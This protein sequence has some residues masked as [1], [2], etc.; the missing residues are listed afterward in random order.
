[1]HVNDEESREL[2]S[3]RLQ[4]FAGTLSSQ[5]QDNASKK[6]NIEERW[7]EDTRQKHGRYDAETE[8]KLEEAGGSKAFSNATRRK[9]KVAKSRLSD[10]VLPADDRNYS[11]SPTPIPDLV[12]AREGDVMQGPNG[13]QIDK[14]KFAAAVEEEAREAAES[15]AKVIDDQLTEARYG[16]KCRDVIDFAVDL[17][18]GILKG[19]VI[20]G[21]TRK[22]WEADPESGLSVL[23]IVQDLAPGVECVSPWDF[24]PD[25][26][27][28]CI[29]DAEFIFE[30][31]PWTKKKLREFAKLP[32]VLTD[33]VK[34]L[35]KAQPRST[36]IAHDYTSEKREISGVQTLDSN[37]L[38][39]VWSYH[40]PISKSDMV[41]CGCE[42]VDED[43]PLEEYEGVVW[44]CGNTVLKASLNP[45]ET[46]D[47]PYSVFCWE[48]D[49]SSIFGFGVP[50]LMR[51]PQKG[52]NRSLG[53]MMMDNGGFAVLPQTVV[54]ETLIEPYDGKWQ[55]T[56]KKLWKKIKKKSKPR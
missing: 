13:E 30:R 53:R 12:N 39:E 31:H 28:T 17:G 29:D 22:K 50:Y 46:E 2:R 48:P 41:L 56:P 55:I 10:V 37:N 8:S 21:N 16:A 43:D 40:G 9:C 26:S 42:G 32:G 15:M 33:Q 6:A 18:T 38:Y 54:D 3:E 11:I 51:N 35:L 25:M 24:Y 44:F 4:L 7:L 49:E 5:C 47:R 52:M 1:M 27:A 14:K 19:P 36:W 45:L 23:N 34:E 20:V